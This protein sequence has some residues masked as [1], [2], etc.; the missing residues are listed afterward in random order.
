M[1]D[2]E[3]GKYWD[4]AWN[5]VTGCTPASEG[6]DHCWAR[7]M[8]ERFHGVGSFATVTFHPD[9]LE[10]PL[11]RRKPSV[12]FVDCCDP[13]HEDVP[14][15]V[16]DRMMAVVAMC[17]HHRF[18]LLTKRPERMQ[19]YFSG[20]GGGRAPEDRIAEAARRV[21]GDEAECRAANAIVGCLGEGHNVGWP[22]RNLWLGV[23]VEA[24]SVAKRIWTLLKTPAMWRWV[25]LE[26]L[27][28]PVDL[29]AIEAMCATWRRGLTIG[30]YLDWV[31]VGG[32]TGPGARPCQ[33]EWIRKIIDQCQAS[34]VPVWVKQLGSQ[35]CRLDEHGTLR[36]KLGLGGGAKDM[37]AW[38]PNLRVRELPADLAAIAGGAA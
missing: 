8:H 6:C 25:S 11:Q 23:T 20:Y 30:I 5:P 22:M 26:P 9:R 35:A 36:L 31:T 1:P 37:A 2:R 13:F 19:G 24:R 21:G 15:E 12:F 34:Q 33:V 17:P 7:A 29:D 18:L 16:L 14:D 4:K 3:T 28:A 10:I 27:I 32:E 38:P